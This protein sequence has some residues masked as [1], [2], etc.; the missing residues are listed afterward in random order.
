MTGA[1]PAMGAEAMRV[2]RGAAIAL[3]CCL[4]A[5]CGPAGTVGTLTAAKLGPNW[6]FTV[7]Q[8]KVV[9]AKDLALFVTSG[10]KAYPLNGEA[11]RRPQ[12]LGGGPVRN[13][14]EIWRPDPNADRLF[15]DARMSLD[16]V[17]H[18]AIDRCTAAGRWIK[19]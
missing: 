19:S 1:T 6:P 18:A 4:V 3:G 10:D 14:A 7:P 13:L 11:E 12:A 15:P 2:W 16:A 9:C 5:A 17:T 8:V